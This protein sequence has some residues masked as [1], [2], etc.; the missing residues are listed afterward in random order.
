MFN[1]K[2]FINGTAICMRFKTE[3]VNDFSKIR[4]EI[5]AEGQPEASK[6]NHT[7]RKASY[8]SGGLI[9]LLK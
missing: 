9:E 8:S 6:V 4:S 7:I 3:S 1:K 2:T 5:I